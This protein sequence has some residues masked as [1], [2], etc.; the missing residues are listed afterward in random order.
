MLFEMKE[1][2][3]NQRFV[4]ILGMLGSQFDGER[5]AAAKKAADLLKEMGLVWEDVIKIPIST[6][7]NKPES[8]KPESKKPESN[9]YC[10]KPTKTG[11]LWYK[12]ADGTTVIIFKHHESGLWKYSLA[13]SDKQVKYYPPGYN[14]GFDEME[15]A[16]ESFEEEFPDYADELS[17]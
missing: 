16:V 5:A 3:N 14:H 13:M 6:K 4:R 9:I 1:Q 2:D 7:N 11:G 17:F 12:F 10:W 15:D 8:K